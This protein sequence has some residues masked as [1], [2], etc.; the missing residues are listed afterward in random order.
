MKVRRHEYEHTERDQIHLVERLWVI[1]CLHQLGSLT[2]PEYRRELA[3][4]HRAP[5]VQPV[6]AKLTRESQRD[7]K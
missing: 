6:E 4:L 5:V 3:A 1:E 7:R 2:K